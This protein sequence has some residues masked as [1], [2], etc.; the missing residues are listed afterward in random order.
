MQTPKFL[1]RAQEAA[2]NSIDRVQSKDKAGW[3]ALFADDAV[4]QDPVGISPLDPTGLGHRGKE[5]I[6]RFW[7]MVNSR[8]QIRFEL[9]ESYPCA[10][11][12]ANVGTFHITAPDGSVSLTK[13]AIVYRVNDKGLILSLKAYWVFPEGFKV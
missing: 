7:D 13:L 5:A 1:N 8:N 2:Y 4:V 3:L 10:D 11:E 12:C 9:R 6:G